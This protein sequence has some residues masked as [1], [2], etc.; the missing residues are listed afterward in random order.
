LGNNGVLL[1]HGLFEHND[2]QKINAE[3]F[4]KLNIQTH[5]IDLPG[6]GNTASNKSDV[7][8]W[9]KIKLFNYL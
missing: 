7:D 2:R 8:S 9:E 5:L 1:L 3:W 4:K 6:H